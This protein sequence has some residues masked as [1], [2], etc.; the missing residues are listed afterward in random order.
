MNHADRPSLRLRLLIVLLVVFVLTALKVPERLLTHIAF[1]VQRGRIEADRQALLQQF[2]AEDISRLTQVF[3][4]VARTA[5]PGVVQ[6]SVEA[7]QRDRAALEELEKRRQTLR[8]RLEEL[9][10]RAHDGN[11]EEDMQAFRDLIDDIARLD[12]E[13]DRLLERLHSGT[14]SGIIFDPA[15]YILTNNHV[16]EGGGT[17][18]VRL[19]DEREYDATLVGTDPKTDLAVIRIEAPDLHALPFGDSDQVEVG[20]WV[21]AVGA[22]FGL[23]HSVTHGIV[24]AKGRADLNVGRDVMY[25]NFIQTDAAI[26]P[27]NSGGPLLNL[28]GEVI[29]VNTA[30]ATNGQPVNA[31]VAFVIPSNM[32]ARVAR[33]LRDTGTVARGWMGITLAELDDT[34]RDKLGVP[35]RLGVLVNAVYVESAA[36]RAGIEV[37]D[38]IIAVDGARVDRLRRLQGLV[39]DISPGQTA[40]FTVI[41]DG[42]RLEIPMKLD[43]QPEDINAWVAQTPGAIA[44]RI[45]PLALAGRMMRPSVVGLVARIAKDRELATRVARHIDDEGVIVLQAD[46][47]SGP[48]PGDLITAADGQPVRT[49]ADLTQALQNHHNGDSITLTWRTPEGKTK[50]ASIKLR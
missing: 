48:Q 17:I 1:A 44:R 26:N 15:G 16:V 45:D 40:T 13:R 43:R 39:A 14:G 31:G 24:S 35:D 30:I 25:Q 4:L 18:R 34:L 7:S 5:R 47:S 36:H 49:L 29:G 33:Q 50:R 2:D 27:G 23:S 9:R 20:D 6:I 28:R 42:R 11:Q 21:L 32:A 12:A 46:R 38:V 41:R 8:R 19:H 3:R 22:P 37:D 10:E